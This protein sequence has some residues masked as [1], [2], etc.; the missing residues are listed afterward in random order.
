MLLR[1]VGHGNSCFVFEYLQRTALQQVNGVFAAVGNVYG[2]LRIHGIFVLVLYAV[3]HSLHLR[4]ERFIADKSLAGNESRGHSPS[5]FP[6]PAFGV[7][8][9][10]EKDILQVFGYYGFNITERQPLHIM[11]G[12]VYYLHLALREP[13][14]IG[15]AGIYCL[16]WHIKAYKP[17]IRALGPVNGR[18]AKSHNKTQHSC[19]LV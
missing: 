6:Q 18:R 17:W 13:V 7:V 3:K 8:V 1:Y 15:V 19:G 4:H 14:P 16:F 9:V 12:C 11:N 10:F 2:K 5:H